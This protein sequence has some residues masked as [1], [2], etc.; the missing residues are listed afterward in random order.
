MSRYRLIIAGCSIVIFLTVEFVILAKLAQ[1][2]S[3]RGQRTSAMP[4]ELVVESLGRPLIRQLSFSELTQS[5]PF[6]ATIESKRLYE[7]SV[8]LFLRRFDGT[9]VVISEQQPNSNFIA[10]VLSLTNGGSYRF[11]SALLE[12]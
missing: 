2:T 8:L 9:E 12:R 6:A 10:R 1:S 4:R 7:T 5:A 11:P 3:S